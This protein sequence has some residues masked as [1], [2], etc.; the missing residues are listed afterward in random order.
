MAR[1]RS[2]GRRRGRPGRPVRTTVTPEQFLFQLRVER[3]GVSAACKRLRISTSTQAK[4]RHKSPE[5]DAEV[6]RILSEPDHRLR[7]FEGRGEVHPASDAPWWQK[8]MHFYRQ[9]RD[10]V[11]AASSVGRSVI[12]LETALRE[13]PE[14]AAVFSEEMARERMQVE[15]ALRRKALKGNRDAAE[16][17]LST[18]GVPTAPPPPVSPAHARLVELF[19]TLGLQ[20]KEWND[21]GRHGRRTQTRAAEAVLENS[22]G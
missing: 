8:F 13:V 17:I 6:R 2:S 21:T 10:R 9:S 11:T 20:G 7:A 5:L 3:L 15:D 19:A 4:W 14:F 18:T 22:A 1:S 16:K 12:E